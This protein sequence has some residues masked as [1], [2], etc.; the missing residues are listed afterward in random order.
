MIKAFASQTRQE[1]FFNQRDD[2]NK[3]AMRAFI[4]NERIIIK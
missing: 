1:Y 4:I 2:F 3:F